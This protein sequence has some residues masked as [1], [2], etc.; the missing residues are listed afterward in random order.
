MIWRHQLSSLRKASPLFFLIS[1]LFT[2]CSLQ[3]QFKVPEDL[4]FR[5]ADVMSEGTRI[6]AEV[7]TPKQPA[8]GRLPTILMS[9]G[10]GGKAKSGVI[11]KGSAFG[12]RPFPVV[13][14]STSLPE[15]RE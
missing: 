14:S 11:L 1:V 6:A 7:F 4:A 3:A 12:V 15:T 8:E 2:T 9:H 10:W 13:T 5:Q